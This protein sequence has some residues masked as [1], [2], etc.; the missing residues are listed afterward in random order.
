[1]DERIRAIGP[2]SA[3]HFD[4]AETSRDRR[5]N[6]VRRWPY[7]LAG[8]CVVGL[9]IYLWSAPSSSGKP[10]PKVPVIPVVAATARM[11]DLDNYLSQIGTVT[12]FATVTVKSRVAGQI[13][14][15]DFREGDAVK[16]GQLLINI[17]PKP[18]EA[19]LQQYTGQLKRDQALL[20]N[21]KITFDRYRDLYKQGVIAR[22][23]LDNQQTLYNQALGTVANDEGLISGVKVNLSY[24]EIT[25]PITGRIGLRLVDLGNYVSATDS[26]VVITQLQPISVI[27]SIAEDYIPQIAAD[28]KSNGQLPVQAWNRDSSKLL[29]TGYLLTF[30]NQIDQ[31]T[32]T[33]KLRAQFANTDYSL[34]PNQFVNARVLV[35]TI[36]NTLL[37]PTAA[38]EKDPQGTLVYLVQPNQVV[39]QREVTVAATQGDLT[40]ITSGLKA[41]DVVVTDGL[42]KLQPG[43]HVRVQPA[44]SSPIQNARE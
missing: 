1:M 28:M 39:T 36:R 38:L 4:R 42:D 2:H 16:A 13:V 9:A 25:A 12:P 20:A 35:N 31:T 22:Q 37:I 17:D 15:I 26:L 40:A 3:T 5:V 21:A 33:V 19:Q 18:Y 32:G 24:C 43:T 10:P 27:F 44:G 30:D 6:Y 11:G 14:K 29:A 41:G 7:W 34:F 8:V 23:D